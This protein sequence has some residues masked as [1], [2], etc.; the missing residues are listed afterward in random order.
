MSEK[1]S[2]GQKAPS[3]ELMGSGGSLINLGNLKGN[4][5]VLYFYPKDDT[6][7]CTI[8]ACE[9]RD[10]KG[11]Y[12][13]TGIKVFGVSADDFDS[14]KNFIN[15]FDLNFELI[16]DENHEICQ[17]YGVLYEKN[18]NGN[19]K[20][21]IKRVTFLIDDNGVIMK[22]WREVDPNGHAQEIIDFIE[23]LNKT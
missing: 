13:Q 22:I 11:I 1:L 5:V 17:K 16:I 19:S 10:M 14:H 4:I 21:S 2:E 6:P 9:F 3:F 7:G 15:K 18:D 23:S 20:L 12:D 8:E